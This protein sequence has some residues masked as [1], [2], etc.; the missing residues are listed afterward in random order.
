M[1][2]EG[3]LRLASTWTFWLFTQVDV[4]ADDCDGEIIHGVLIVAPKV[5]PLLILGAARGMGRASIVDA[6][7]DSALAIYS[8]S[9]VQAAIL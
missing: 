7:S 9:L 4:L 6:K 5:R 1:W 8:T 3:A 2:N